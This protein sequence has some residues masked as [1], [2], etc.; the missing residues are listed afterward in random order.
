MEQYLMYLRKSQMDRDFEDVSVEETLKRHKKILTDF[1]KQKRLNVVHTLEEVVSGESL[2]E[3]PQMMKCLELVNTGNFDGVICMDIDRLSRGSSLDSGYIMQVLQ[4]SNCKIVT[5]SKIYDLAN[6]SDEQ[7]TDMKFMFSRYELRTITKRLIRGRNQSAAEG[8]YL[9]SSPPYG[10]DIIKLKGEKGNSLE[11]NPEQAKV[12][13]MIFDMYTEQN[14][15][16][17]TI[18][19]EL[20]KMHIPT[21]KQGGKWA[22]TTVLDILR[23]PVYIGKI[24]WKKYVTTKVMVDGKLTKKRVRNDDHELHDGLHEPI[25]TEEQFQRAAELRSQKYHVPKN[26]NREIMNPFAGLMYCK[27]CGR[28][29]QRY[30]R[31]DDT[32]VKPRYKCGTVGCGCRSVRIEDLENAVVSEMK[33]WLEGYMITIE[34]MDDLNVNNDLSVALQMVESQLSEAQNQQNKICELLEKGIYSIEVFSK[35]NAVLTADIER[36]TA[37]KDDLMR[38]IENQNKKQTNVKNILPITQQL[39]DS[40]DDLNSKEKNELWKQVLEKII[41]YREVKKGDFEVHIYPKIPS[42]NMT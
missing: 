23:N 3:R 16:V 21:Q 25:I 42:L 37:D 19:Y 34:Q 8:K 20:N 33:K 40:Y 22:K 15:G 17:E 28:P 18:L 6:E 29:I 7:F 41:Y 31:Y 14:M 36:L 5:P 27:A 13:Q 35:R 10:Y 32:N 38:Q 26:L 9:G 12:V 2:S 30:Q 39:L 4:I 11:I 24:R 1:A